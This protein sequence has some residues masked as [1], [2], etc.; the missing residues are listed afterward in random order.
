M[1]E[2]APGKF[3]VRWWQV[4]RH[5][6][7]KKLSIYYVRINGCWLP[8]IFYSAFQDSKQCTLICLCHYFIWTGHSQWYWGKWVC[9][10]S[11]FFLVART[12]SRPN[13]LC[14]PMRAAT[15][16][17]LALRFFPHPSSNVF[18][19]SFLMGRSKFLGFSLHDSMNSWC[20]CFPLVGRLLQ[21][22]FS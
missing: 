8:M 16:L 10:I 17:F 14:V 7:Q 5:V 21:A 12:R 20:L 13:R 22:S 4:S 3:P 15:T 1:K 2:N 6:M 18:N 19:F 9:C 11:S